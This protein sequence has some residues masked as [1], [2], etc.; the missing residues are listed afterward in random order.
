M[1][2]AFNSL[3]HGEIAF[4]FLHAETDL[5]MLHTYF[6]FA[7]HFCDGV[8]ALAG[9][10][11]RER[12]ESEWE[13]YML[14]EEQIGSLSGAVHGVDLRGFMGDVYRRFP[15]PADM[16]TF[17]RNPEGEKTQAIV[18]EMIERYERPARVPVA[19]DASGSTIEIGDYMF[20]RE[21][22][23]NLLRYVWA[24]GYPAWKAGTRPGYLITM[25]ERV[26]ASDHPLFDGIS[27]FI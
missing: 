6:I 5:L 20:S 19:V 4:G 18:R 22:F 21:A 7:S 11:A 26:L 23:H 8:A 12:L 9:G 16:K 24:G 14:R 25:K 3:S 10:P 27:A 17:E 13:V 1:S 15:L 2:L